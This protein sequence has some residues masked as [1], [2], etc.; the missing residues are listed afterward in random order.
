M[1]LQDIISSFDISQPF[2]WRLKLSE[3]DFNEL[4]SCLEAVSASKGV[5]S[6]ALQEHAKG[7]LIYV[8]E[9]YKR[10]YQSGNK[11]DLIDGLDLETLWTNT[12]ISKNLF[13][14]KDNSGNNRWL[15]SIY[16]LGGLAIQ[17]ELNRNDNMRFLKGLCRIYHGENYTLE[18]IDEAS[19][20]VA[21]RESIKRKHSLYEYL[22]EILNGEM[23][24]HKNDLADGSSYINRFV[25][26][27]KA[28][29][30]EILKVKFRFEWVVNFS[31]EFNCMTRRL[32]IWLKPEEVGGELH[33]YLRYDRVHLWGVPNPE[34]QLHLYVFIRFMNGDSI[35]EPSLMAKPIITY[36]N[37]SLNDFVAFGVGKG[38]QIKHLPTSP[39][40]RVEL[41]VKD[42]DGNEYVAQVQES[43]E[44]IQLWRTDP[45]S[46]TWTSTLNTQKETALLFSNRCQLI[47][48]PISQEVFRKR[49]RDQRFGTSEV[50]N[51]SYIYDSISFSDENGKEYTL[52]NRIGYDQITTHLY[53][54]IIHYINGGK[55]KHIYIDDPDESDIP[56]VDEYPLIFGWD[57]LIVRHFSTKDDILN[58]QPESDTVA[59]LIEWKNSN[60]RYTE[61]TDENEPPFGEVQLRLTVKGKP[62]SFTAIYL[63][64][65]DAES[66]VKRDYYTTCIRYRAIDK[67]VASIKDEINKDGTPL[68]PTISL[69]YGEDSNYFELDVYR[70]TLIKEVIL[71]GKI[72]EYLDGEDKLSLPYIFKD[73]VQLNDF[74]THGYQAYEC[75]NLCSIYSDTYIN[76]S[77][78]Q[79]AGW[80]ALAAWN[81]N[82][83]YHGALLDKLAP[84]SLSVYFGQSANDS[85]WDEHEALCWN[86]D[87][88]EDPHPVN[89]SDVPDFGV[90]YQNLSTNKDLSCNFPIQADDDPW[91]FDDVEV[92]I[93]K[94]FEMANDAGTYFFLMR[95]LIDLSKKD[96][97][98]EIY[99]PLLRSRNGVLTIKDKMGLIRFAEEFGFDWKEFD[100]I[101]DTE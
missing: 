101:I 26:A 73:R 36:L 60:G 38:V 97:M 80:A 100:V 94:C 96:I 39:F 61:W 29:N 64:R 21:F 56:E 35:V 5:S 82:A 54:D 13:L 32:N 55:V 22:K 4:E 6:L 15:Y 76:I 67:S 66:P 52:F 83:M 59:E 79:N 14:Y 27:V 43:S 78:N 1:P 44:Y 3:T 62:Y 71:D 49:F 18:N 63:P 10:K 88:N 24:F 28:A 42:D 53:S 12:G 69:K 85:N 77:G 30:D 65:L 34:K 40:D 51:W 70:P 86:Y 75:K 46:D 23:P 90:I 68:F 95:P 72:V 9:W 47:S 7:T 17:H 19:R 8:A 92:S 16:V 98:A 33:Q 74:S 99:E 57:D 37:H 20:A 58:V 31:P 81:K 91:G 50:W 25:S 93:L 45:L 84:D 87:V 2:V 11:C 89:P 41:F 48:D